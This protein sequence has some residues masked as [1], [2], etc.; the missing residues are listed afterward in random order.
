MVTHLQRQFRFISSQKFSK[1]LRKIL[2]EI[3]KVIFELNLFLIYGIRSKLYLKYFVLKYFCLSWQQIVVSFKIF[4]PNSQ[5]YFQH[6]YFS[7]DSQSAHSP[8]CFNSSNTHNKCSSP[9]HNRIKWTIIFNY[10]LK[11][12]CSTI[13]LL[14]ESPLCARIYAQVCVD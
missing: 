2:F 14:R 12:P 10:I 9:F 3:M 11:Y 13:S 1:C 4:I 8:C 5:L 6:N 7:M